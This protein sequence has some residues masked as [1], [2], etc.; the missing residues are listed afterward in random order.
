MPYIS[1]VNSLELEHSTHQSELKKLARKN[2]SK[3]YNDIERLLESFD[4]A[5]IE[6]RNLCVPLEY[7]DRDNTFRQRNDDYTVFALELSARVIR[8]LLG[9]SEVDGREV[10]DIIFVS[11]TGISTPSIDAAVINRLAL[12]PNVNRIPLWGLGCAGGVSGISLACRL[13]SA[14]PFAKILVV[15]VELCSLTFIKSDMSKSNLIATGLFSDGVAAALVTGDG[16]EAFA[17]AGQALRY[18]ASKSKTYSDSLDV[19]GW[20]LTEEGLKVI[21]SRDIPNI[22]SVKVKH[23]VLEF[24]GSAQTGIA[25]VSDYVVHP[26][27]VKVIDSYITS[28]GIDPGKFSNTRKVLRKFGNMSSATVMYVLHEFFRNGFSGDTAFMASLGPGF[29]SEMALFEV[30]R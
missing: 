21:F 8:D 3:A 17:P 13:A 1:A 4:N 26:G 23:D 9:K 27:G 7:F 14:N 25:K 10:T 24:L 19:M 28:L 11:S 18:I 29:S 22:V 6:C 12:N 5:E 15:T 2:F 30:I 20:E 16:L